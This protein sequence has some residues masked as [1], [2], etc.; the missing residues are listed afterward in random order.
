MRQGTVVGE[1]LLVGH[2]RA[3]GFRFLAGLVVEIADDIGA[4]MADD[5]F[6]DWPLEFVFPC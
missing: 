4:M 6:D 1:I 3:V 2:W 5:G